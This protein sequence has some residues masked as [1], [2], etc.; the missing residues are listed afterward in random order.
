ML[1]PAISLV[2]TKLK[3]IR[4]SQ[5]RRPRVS[6][7]TLVRFVESRL[8]GSQLAP[9]KSE[10]LELLNSRVSSCTKCPHLASVPNIHGRH[11]NPADSVLE[12]EGVVFMEDGRV[13][14]ER[15][16]WLPDIASAIVWA[17]PVRQRRASL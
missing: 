9:G 16:L 11:L 5:E 13:D 4:D 8:Q 7:D 17:C 3:E 6:R 2:L 15:Y 12:A 1:E 14:L 10:L